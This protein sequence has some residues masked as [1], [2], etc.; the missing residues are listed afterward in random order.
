MRGG[1]KCHPLI[2]MRARKLGWLGALVALESAAC[3]A[4][5]VNA[6]VETTSGSTDPGPTVTTDVGTSTGS[7]TSTTVA[8]ESS[9]PVETTGVPSTESSTGPTIYFDVGGGMATEDS[10]SE[11][12][13]GEIID[14][15]CDDLTTP[16]ISQL[17]LVAPRAYHDVSFDDDGNLVGYDGTS[18]LAVSYDDV[19]SVFVPNPGGTPQGIDRLENGDFLFVDGYEMRRVTPDQQVSVV[20]GGLSGAY[21]IT[22]GPDQLAYVCAGD[23]VRVDPETGVI[24][25]W[26]DVGVT[27]RALVFNLDST[28]VYISTLASGQVYYVP[29]DENLDPDGPPV[30]FAS[31]VGDGYHDGLGID[32]C[33]NLYV[34]DYYTSGLYRVDPDGVVTVLYSGFQ[35]HYGHGLDWGSGIGGWNDHAIYL[36]QPYDNYTVNEVDLGVPSGSRVRTWEGA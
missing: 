12:S 8:M 26:V 25:P 30:L 15:D 16:F 7:P 9:G 34:P 4:P 5:A 28:G 11:S 17:E 27:A 14:W 3:A 33:G 24:T 6:G 32:A 36:P 19:V 2:L 29:V 18:L 21:G 31:N 20:T 10:G 35:P 23:V 1:P 22:V 13:T